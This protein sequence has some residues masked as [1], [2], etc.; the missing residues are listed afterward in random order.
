MFTGH[1]FTGHVFVLFNTCIVINT[2]HAIHTIDN[3]MRN[4]MMIAAIIYNKRTKQ[5]SLVPLYIMAGIALL[6]FVSSLVLL[7]IQDTKSQNKRDVTQVV[8]GMV[9]GGIGI[10]VMTVTAICIWM[11]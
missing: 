10:L 3:M 2:A 5:M 7:I 6:F 8:I 1:V 4:P 11:T 9:L